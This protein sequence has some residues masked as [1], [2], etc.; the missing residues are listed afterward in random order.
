MTEWPGSDPNQ[1]IEANCHS[2]CAGVGMSSLGC[3]I[4]SVAS[5]HMFYI[6]Y[7]YTHLFILD[8]CFRFDSFL[9]IYSKQRNMKVKR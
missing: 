2:Y 9:I 8:G 4:Y 1:Q 6:S 5:Q 7:Y 3:G